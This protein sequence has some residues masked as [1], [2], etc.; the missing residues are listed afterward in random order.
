VALCL[1]GGGARSAIFSVGV[2]QGLARKDLLRRIDYLSTVGGG[3]WT[4]AWLAR[5]G[6]PQEVWEMLADRQL[7]GEVS[8]VERLPQYL[9]YLNPF[10]AD[11][12]LW[13]T[14]A[15]WNIPRPPE[16]AGHTA[17]ALAAICAAACIRR[18]ASYSQK[19][20]PWPTVLAAT[21]ALGFCGAWAWYRR[22]RGHP[23]GY[24]ALA[25][26]AAAVC[27]GGLASRGKG[28]PRWQRRR[29]AG[30]ITVFAVAASSGGAYSRTPARWRLPEPCMGGPKPCPTR[31]P[32]PWSSGSQIHRRRG[33]RH[34][35]RSGRAGF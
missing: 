2:L 26:V 25:G 33:R 30:V 6:K 21:A 18:A 34:N 23:P 11:P 12:A 20:S 24:L 1:S 15:L 29:V 28:D 13:A 8:P 4:G 17:L 3:G 5:S 19:A 27:A 16:A 35:R 14:Q 7:P 10:A 9:P 22:L 31:A 32:P